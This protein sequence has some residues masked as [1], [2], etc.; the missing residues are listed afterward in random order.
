MLLGRKRK[1][2]PIRLEYEYRRRCNYSV[3]TN[4][5]YIS[6]EISRYSPIENSRV[7]N[8]I[9]YL[10]YVVRYFH[11]L[12]KTTLSSRSK[13]NKRPFANHISNFFS[14]NLRKHA[15]ICPPLILLFPS[16]Y[17]ITAQIGKLQVPALRNARKTPGPGNI[18]MTRTNRKAPCA[19]AS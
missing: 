17:R 18:G 8:F 9:S 1:L 3:E 13:R 4:H 2:V 7:S 16:R 14:L 10:I 6:I 5:F 12:A 19:S 11:T 15:S